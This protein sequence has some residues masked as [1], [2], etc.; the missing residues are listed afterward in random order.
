M[1]PPVLHG[2]FWLSNPIQL[3]CEI[4]EE[5]MRTETEGTPGIYMYFDIWKCAPSKIS[6]F[7]KNIRRSVSKT[8]LEI[9]WAQD[10]VPNS[11]ESGIS[12]TFD[13]LHGNL[14]PEGQ[15]I[16]K[17]FNNI[18]S[19]QVLTLPW[20]NKVSISRTD[21]ILWWKYS[22]TTMSRKSRLW[23]FPLK[24]C[25]K[26]SMHCMSLSETLWFLPGQII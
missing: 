4:P 12:S 25:I 6:K 18:I 9:H 24:C 13:P 14:V 17:P 8:Y 22:F 19:Y 26:Q 20:Y 7:H 2:N 11:D 3:F 1:I 16:F 23:N 5:G 10:L 15:V 21:M